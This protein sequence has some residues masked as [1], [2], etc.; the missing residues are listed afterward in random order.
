MTLERPYKRSKRVSKPSGQKSFKREFVVQEHKA[1]T[2]H[3]DFRLQVDNKMM[4]WAIP[5]GPSLNPRVARLAIET[6]PHD[7]DYNRFEGVIEKGLY[8]A[9]RVMTWDVGKYSPDVNIKDALKRGIVPF[10]LKGKKLKG[11]W[12]L[13]RTGGKKSK[14]WLLVKMRDKYSTTTVDI[15]KDM[16]KSVRSG[17]T[18][19]E[20]TGA[21]GHITDEVDIGWDIGL[22]KLKRKEGK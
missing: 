20:I 11:K 17:K 2:K 9:G 12:V 1:R 21:D 7:M 18:I 8:G 13:I 15:I 4:S 14:N 19:H 5:K 10:T 22:Y 16:P 3:W 6:Y